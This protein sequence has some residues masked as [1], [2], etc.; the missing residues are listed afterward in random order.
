M[1][2]R[3]FHFMK[4]TA[5]LAVVLFVLS[6]GQAWAY[7]ALSVSSLGDNQFRLNVFSAQ[8]FSQVDLYTRQSD[9][10]LWT[11]FYNVARTDS[12]GNASTTIS[13]GSW[14]PEL[15][16]E[17]YAVVGNETTGITTA[18]S[19]SQQGQLTFSAGNLNLTTGDSRIINVFGANL[20]TLYVASNS[21]SSAASVTINDTT[22]ITIRGMA[23]G[24]ATTRISTYD[25][26]NSGTISVTVSDQQLNFLTTSLAQPVINQYYSQRI[27]ASG[28]LGPYRYVLVSG[29]LPSGMILTED[30]FIQGYPTYA[31]RTSFE[32]RATDS[33][34]RQVTRT[35]QLNVGSVLGTSTFRQNG[36]LVEQNG[37]VYQVYR[38]FRTGFASGQ[39]FEGL[40]YRFANVER[41]AWT[42]LPI[43]SYV[44][45]TSFTSHPWGS[46]VKSGNT[47]YF[48][49]ET[50]LIP[51]PSYDIFVNNGGEDRLVVP[52]NVYD[53]QLPMQTNMIY[54]DSRSA[55]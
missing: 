18:G 41:G 37:T 25:N 42:N 16:R 3:S 53:S 35:F 28:G 15:V 17:F 9:T 14:R 23:A 12:A 29:I 10:Q 32:V 44:V 50:G 52:L 34:N 26:L 7:A 22:S 6:A 20:K 47:V 13:I 30:G 33:Q 5:A 38:G 46:W 21:N 31:Q 43:T 40:G 2:F 19:S 36:H 49:H 55:S 54:D 24:S 48:V 8:T 1:N 51:V 45:N 39:A 11:V 4:K 27:F